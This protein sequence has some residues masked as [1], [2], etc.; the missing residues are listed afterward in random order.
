MSL[1]RRAILTSTP[2]K[3]ENTPNRAIERRT[4]ILDASDDVPDFDTPR[5]KAT[6]PDEQRKV[7][8]AKRRKAMSDNFANPICYVCGFSYPPI[9]HLHHLKPLNEGG[10]AD[11]ETVWLCP[12]CHAM[13][14]EIRRM[15]YR[16]RSGMR[17]K[18]TRDGHFDYWLES[19]DR[20]VAKKLFEYA[21]YRIK[22]AINPYDR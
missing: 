8:A 2:V 7:A 21:M 12:N 1:L 15:R 11:G 17:Y 13:V 9:M 20:H 4:G 14:H 5:R 6:M 18:K 16:Y 10:N 3:A 22:G 19:C